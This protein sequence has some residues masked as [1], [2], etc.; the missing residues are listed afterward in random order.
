M[1]TPLQWFGSNWPTSPLQETLSWVQTKMVD[2]KSWTID[3]AAL[4]HSI[5]RKKAPKYKN[6][7]EEKEN[8]LNWVDIQLQ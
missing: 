5:S 4:L 1:Q 7:I 6:L 2:I 8:T 3:L